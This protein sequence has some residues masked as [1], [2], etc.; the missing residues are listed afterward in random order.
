M[1]RPPTASDV[2]VTRY[3]GYARS[4]TVALTGGNRQGTPAALPPEGQT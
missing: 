2:A 1:L 3:P 4:G